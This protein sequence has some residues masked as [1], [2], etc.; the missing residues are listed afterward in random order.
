MARII[1]TIEHAT[2]TVAGVD[3]AVTELVWDDEGRSFEVH[4]L[5]DGTDLTEAACFDGHP[6][7]AEI[8][9]LLSSHAEC[10]HGGD[11]R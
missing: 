11:R 7:D 5:D 9:A 4:R 8:T 3:V 6:S 2:R 10:G 1:R